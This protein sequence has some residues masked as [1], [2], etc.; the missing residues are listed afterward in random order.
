MMNQLVTSSIICRECLNFVY[1]F[2][3]IEIIIYEITLENDK[4]MQVL[5]WNIK[6]SRFSFRAAVIFM[7]CMQQNSVRCIFTDCIMADK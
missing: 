6:P 1:A 3:L 2:F 5:K 7:H 4:T